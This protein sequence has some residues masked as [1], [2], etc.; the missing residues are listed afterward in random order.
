MKEKLK[1]ASENHLAGVALWRLG[2]E[3]EEFWETVSE[4]R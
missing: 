1:L 2:Y 3:E 4:F